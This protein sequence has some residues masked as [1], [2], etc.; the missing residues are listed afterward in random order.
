LGFVSDTTDCDDMRSAINPAAAEVCDALDF[1]EDCDG[2][3]EDADASVTNTSAW[4]PDDD[5]DGYGVVAGSVTACAMPAGYSANA[6][7]CAE[8]TDYNCDGS[9]GFSDLDADGVPACLDCDDGDAQSF[10]GATERCD[11]VDDDCD[12]TVDEADAV[13]A[14]TWYLDADADGWGSAGTTS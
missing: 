1:D 10:P 12:G 6:S 14:S 7:D 8:P 5:A 4:Y 3:A 9:N 2:L 11:G 13:D